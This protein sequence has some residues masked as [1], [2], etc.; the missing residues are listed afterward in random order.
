[1]KL[2]LNIEQLSVDSFEA[3]PAAAEA[4]GTVRANASDPQTCYP[5]LCYSG[6]ES[7][8]GSCDPTCGMSCWGTCIPAYCQGEES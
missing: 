8:L 3:A 6:A 5:V 4:Q 1:M 7:C 2:K